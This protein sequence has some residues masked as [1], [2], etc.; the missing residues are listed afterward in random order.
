[1]GLLISMGGRYE[2]KTI[3]AYFASES[4]NQIADHFYQ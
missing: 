1:M 3:T 2:A 4:F